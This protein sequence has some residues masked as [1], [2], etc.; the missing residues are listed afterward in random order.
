MG[1]DSDG[2]EVERHW[3]I[4][5]WL[6]EEGRVWLTDLCDVC[7]VEWPCAVELDRRAEEFSQVLTAAMMR[8]ICSHGGYPLDRLMPPT[9]V[10]G[11]CVL[12]LNEALRED[13]TED[14]EGWRQ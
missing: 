3:K 1:V 9:W 8:P 10:C 4:N 13:E 2:A 14:L 11:L 7:W 12:E 6:D 5:H